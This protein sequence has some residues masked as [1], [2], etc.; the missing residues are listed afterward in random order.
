MIHVLGMEAKDKV[1]TLAMNNVGTMSYVT[2]SEPFFFFFSSVVVN[3]TT[4]KVS[5]QVFYGK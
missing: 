2:I 3:K 4:L 1:S 5:K